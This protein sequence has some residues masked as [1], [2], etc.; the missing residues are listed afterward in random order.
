VRI[1]VQRGDETFVVD[2]D[3]IGILRMV[4]W[5]DEQRRVGVAL[6]VCLPDAAQVDVQV[7]VAVEDQE[8]VGEPRQRICQ[9]A[10][11]AA[12]CGFHRILDAEAVA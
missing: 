6:F 7:G 3:E 11:C 1:R 8:R 4:V 2:F 9:S 10:G 5:M 12:R